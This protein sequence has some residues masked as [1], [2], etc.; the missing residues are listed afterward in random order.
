MDIVYR[1]PLIECRICERFVMNVKR[2]TY[3]YST[4]TEPFISVTCKHERDCINR[5]I[6]QKEMERAEHEK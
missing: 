3:L 5:V 6:K 2:Q 1:L 4:N